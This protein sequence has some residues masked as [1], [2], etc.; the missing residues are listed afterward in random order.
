MIFVGTELDLEMGLKIEM[1][2]FVGSIFDIMKYFEMASHGYWKYPWGAHFSWRKSPSVKEI[3]CS[4]RNLFRRRSRLVGHSRFDNDRLGLLLPCP[5]QKLSQLY[6]YL[7]IVSMAI[8]RMR[9]VY[10]YIYTII[11]ICILS[12]NDTYNIYIYIYIYVI[13]C[14]IV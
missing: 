3:A 1:C 8:C 14:N 10:I 4:Q 5:A 6:S 2:I 13:L 11:C 9:I 12:T 7:C